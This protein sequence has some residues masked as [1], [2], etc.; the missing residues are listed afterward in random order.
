[1][2]FRSVSK[3]TTVLNVF[4]CLFSLSLSL[5]LPLLLLLFLIP[6]LA[7]FASFQSVFFSFCF[8]I[9][10]H[11]S[12]NFF[13]VYEISQTNIFVMHT[14]YLLF[15]RSFQLKWIH[16]FVARSHIRSWFGIVQAIISLH[17]AQFR[18]NLDETFLKRF[19]P[20]QK[21][22]NPGNFYP[23]INFDISLKN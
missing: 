20:I 19:V 3:Q 18:W 16:A 1:M 6:L 4:L 15:P 14:I 5:P 23:P 13:F 2:C 12:F 22:R 7:I 11:F 17:D 9:F 21:I 8:H 10:F